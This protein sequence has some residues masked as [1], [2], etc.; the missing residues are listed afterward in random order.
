LPETVKKL[1]GW[2][3]YLRTRVAKSYDIDVIVDH[4]TLMRLRAKYELS[5][6]HHVSGRKFETKVDG[7]GVDIYPVYQ[8]K[9]GR[10]LQS[11]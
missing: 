8:S 1:G 10:L 5:P 2:A 3:S 9:L 7:V 6:S 11:N 4:A